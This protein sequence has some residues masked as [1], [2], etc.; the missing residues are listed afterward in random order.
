MKWNKKRITYVYVGN[1]RGDNQGFFEATQRFLY[2]LGCGWAAGGRS[3]IQR[4]HRDYIQVNTT[5]VITSAPTSSAEQSGNI[6][7]LSGLICEE[8]V[9]Y[10][11]T[12]AGKDIEVSEESY[13]ALKKS[14][15]EGE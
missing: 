10:T 11:I 6:V 4:Y 14:L 5:G 3:N 15:L 12:I 1:H 13:E 9:T 2:S 8:E 7:N